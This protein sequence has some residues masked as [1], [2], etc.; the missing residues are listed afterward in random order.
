MKKLRLLLLLFVSVY[1]FYSV[2][3]QLFTIN[4]QFV[5]GGLGFD[6]MYQTKI[7]KLNNGTYLICGATTTDNTGNLV[8]GNYG[9]E[10]YLIINFNSD[11]TINWQKNY[12]GISH[13]GAFDVIST[14]DGGFICLGYSDSPIGGNKTE[15]KYGDFDYWVIK[16]DEL[17]NE[18]WQKTYGGNLADS[19]SEILKTNDGN[20]LLVGASSSSVS[21]NKT[22]P[23]KGIVDYWLVKIDDLGNIIWDKTIGGS[24]YE[25]ISDSYIDDSGNIYLAGHSSSNQSFD[26]TENSFGGKDVWIVK[27]SSNGDVI[28]SK[29]IGTDAN[30]R[31]AFFAFDGKN[32]FINTTLEPNTTPNIGNVASQSSN[33]DFLLI[34]MDTSGTI[35]W[36]KKYGGNG[37]EDSQGIICVN[38]NLILFGISYSNISG[39]KTENS[40]GGADL[41]CVLVN[42][43]NGNV[44]RDKTFGGVNDEF[45]G[46]VYQIDMN[47]FLLAI[48]TNSSV[49]GDITSP[50]YGLDDI[51]LVDVSTTID[52]GVNKIKENSSISIFPNPLSTHFTIKNDKYV[53]YIILDAQGQFISS[54]QLYKGENVIDVNQVK[55][56]V[57]FLVLIDEF[58]QKTTKRLVKY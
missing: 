24:G 6:N 53:S 29:T 52:L 50:T 22:T 44:I 46:A 17:G 45:F 40:R 47:N 10:D 51:W 32:I 7:I 14:N 28:W 21:G 58:N 15:V 55:T 9:L 12:G 13:D 43:N 34:K 48:N 42:G 36:D 16:F 19:G 23:N 4:S 20:Y 57:Y 8:V 27:L 30:E 56:G 41:W 31:F 37:Y 18:I 35:V 1:S 25:V 38:S 2:S 5:L 11:F 26:K 49:S 39:D 33:G 54:S 3:Q